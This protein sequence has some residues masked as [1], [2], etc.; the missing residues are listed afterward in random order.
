MIRIIPSSETSAL[1]ALREKLSVDEGL[2]TPASRRMTRKVFGRDL[3]P[4][5]VVETICRDVRKSGDKAVLI[6]GKKLDRADLTVR[7][8]RVPAAELAKA[9]KDADPA[10]KSALKQA[11]R[12]ILDYQKAILQKGSRRVVKKE[13][14]E[15][16]LRVLPLER[17]GIYIPAGVAPLCSSVLM[18]VLP[19]VAA[20]VKEIVACSPPRNGTVDPAIL[21]ALKF[22]GVE[23]V[24]RTGGVQALAAMAYG[25]ATI[26]AVDKIAGP[27]NLFVA[28]AKKHLFGQTDIDLIAGPSEIAVIADD[29][30]RPGFVAL[31]LMA[32]AEHYPGSAVLLTDSR[33]F[34]DAVNA[35]IRERLAGLSRSDKIAED[36]KEFSLIVVCRDI[37]E[38]CRIANRLGPEHLSVN[39]RNPKKAVAAVP[40]A[41][42]V[43]VGP[44]TPVALGDYFAGP[45]HTLP[46]G[47]SSRSFSGLNA[48]Q[49]LRTVAV[50]KSDADYLK[51]NG[52]QIEV[53]AA[54]E[55]LTAHAASVS[56]RRHK[57]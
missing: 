34:A 21:A 14:L 41:G 55:G 46:T 2:T 5:E 36:L 18:N 49:F 39:V 8:L 54:K 4:R 20:G 10:F 25:T 9:W 45:S 26:P 28:L 29:S 23:R 7:S 50:M 52:G 42:A 38:A 17:V 53:L 13:G 57:R 22:C 19:A 47:G 1:E 33:K 44:W 56:E 15:I 6:Y 27:G 48:N 40:N 37:D 32:Q 12:N 3:S 30:A 51:K 16:D 31:D 11:G 43:F 24:Y 35:E